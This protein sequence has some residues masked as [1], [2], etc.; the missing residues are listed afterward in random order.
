MYVHCTCAKCSLGLFEYAIHVIMCASR[1]KTVVA[2][3]LM[4]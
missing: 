3:R 2:F 4:F 1:T